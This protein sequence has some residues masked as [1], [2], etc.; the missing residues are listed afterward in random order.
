MLGHDTV[1]GDRDV[2]LCKEQKQQRTIAHTIIRSPKILLIDKAT[3][4]LDID[5]ERVV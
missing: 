1:V 2:Q 3:S 4:A 5:Y